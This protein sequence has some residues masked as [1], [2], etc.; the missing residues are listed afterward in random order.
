M[1][2]GAW[3]TRIMRDPGVNANRVCYWG[4]SIAGRRLGE[5]KA[6][7]ARLLPASVSAPAS[8]EAV[9]PVTNLA[10]SPSAV[11]PSSCTGSIG[12]GFPE[13]HLPIESSAD[14]ACDDIR[15]GDEYYR[16]RL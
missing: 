13:I 1:Q 14:A 9:E 12:I 10:S 8:S 2:P 7:S 6:D 15:V 4:S 11:M 5:N 16:L 3:I